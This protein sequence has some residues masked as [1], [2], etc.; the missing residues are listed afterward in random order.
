MFCPTRAEGPL[1]RVLLDFSQGG[2]D[3]HD[4]RLGDVVAALLADDDAQLGLE[5]VGLEARRAVVEV[6]LDHDS[7]IVGEL[8]VE[9][10]VQKLHSLYAVLIHVSP[11]VRVPVHAD[12]RIRTTASVAP[13]F[14]D[15]GDSSRCR[16]ARPG[17]QRSPCTKILPRHRAGP[18]SGTARGGPRWPP[19]PRSR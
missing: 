7:A 6:T 1:F 17:S 9:V 11:H 16:W 13:F 3:P 5:V 12:V 10:V 4:Q 15:G 14:R 18:P 19:S 2:G 8:A